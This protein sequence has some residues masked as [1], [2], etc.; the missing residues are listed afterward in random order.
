[1]TKIR[2]ILSM[3]LIVALLASVINIGTAAGGTLFVGDVNSGGGVDNRDAMILDRVAANW[4]G[5]YEKYCIK[6]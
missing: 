6:V 3:L 4:A 5:Y 2:K 1:M